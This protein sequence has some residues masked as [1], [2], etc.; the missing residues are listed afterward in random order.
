[1]KNVNFNNN[2]NGGGLVKPPL[3]IET[4][5][6]LRRVSHFRLPLAGR[7][8]REIRWIRTE[9]R[10]HDP[11]ASWTR[12]DKRIEDRIAVVL[13]WRSEGCLEPAATD[14]VR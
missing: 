3:Q 8:L 13:G 10:G 11:A 9:T 4:R 5:L 14:H 2:L 12:C 1:M 7:S 6:L